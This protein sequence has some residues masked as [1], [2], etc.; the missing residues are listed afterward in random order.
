MIAYDNERM[1]EWIHED[2]VELHNFGKDI[3]GKIPNFDPKVPEVRG[4]WLRDENEIIDI[5]LT[6]GQCA[7]VDDRQNVIL[8]HSC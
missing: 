7:V 5:F 3:V 8:C 2:V 4:G 1:L 6:R